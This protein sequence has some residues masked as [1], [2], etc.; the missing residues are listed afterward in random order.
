MT[1]FT[2]GQR[3]AAHCTG[4]RYSQ[5][6]ARTLQPLVSSYFMQC[7][8]TLPCGADRVLVRTCSLVA[9]FTPLSQDAG[10]TFDVFLASSLGK[11]KYYL[12]E[13]MIRFHISN[14]AVVVSLISHVEFT[15]DR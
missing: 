4:S 6:M 5:W 14:L 3:I 10:D 12:K 13:R 7:T 15:I 11:Y 9:A 2:E 1:V 8:L